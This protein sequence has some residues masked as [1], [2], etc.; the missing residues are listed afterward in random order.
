MI[1]SIA[2]RRSG[3]DKRRGKIRRCGKGKYEAYR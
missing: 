3:E 2:G 1:V